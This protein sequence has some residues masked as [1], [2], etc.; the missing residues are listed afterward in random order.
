MYSGVLWCHSCFDWLTGIRKTLIGCPVWRS[1]LVG[2]RIFTPFSILFLSSIFLYSL[3]HDFYYFP[4]SM[5]LIPLLH[6]HLHLLISIVF[7][8]PPP[9]PP[10]PPH[11]YCFP[12]TTT[13]TTSSFLLFFPPPPHF[14]CFSS[15]SFSFYCFPSKRPKGQNK[16]ITFEFGLIG[17]I[18]AFW[19]F[20]G[21]TVEMRRRWW[22]WWRRWWRENNRM[23][24]RRRRRR[25]EKR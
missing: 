14:Y 5:F 1:I 8:S 12:T 11:F 22:W 13:T 2:C 6:L 23:R 3:L 15:S 18:L 17:L 9:P 16:T 4:S 24:R 20:R 21:K 25:R 19:S 7:S 10:P